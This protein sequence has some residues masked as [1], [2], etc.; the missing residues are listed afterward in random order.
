[1]YA[2]CAIVCASSAVKLAAGEVAG[3]AEHAAPDQ[4]VTIEG[5]GSHQDV[6]FVPRFYQ[7]LHLGA[8]PTDIGLRLA[9][10]GHGEP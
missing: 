6:L 8:A 9:H 3:A 5:Q 1:M 7:Y 10:G 2:S 4:C